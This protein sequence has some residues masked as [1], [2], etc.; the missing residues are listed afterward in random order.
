MDLST[1]LQNDRQRTDADRAQLQVLH[2]VQGHSQGT[3]TGADQITFSIAPAQYMS[4][5]T[6]IND[7]TQN[8]KLTSNTQYKSR[9]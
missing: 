1:A 4:A 8:G 6:S 5:S 7:T 2:Q 9:S 3:G